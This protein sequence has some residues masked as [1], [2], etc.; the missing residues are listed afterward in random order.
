MSSR[1]N[2]ESASSSAPGSRDQK[3]QGDSSAGLEWPPKR[4]H[5]TEFRPEIPPQCW[6]KTQLRRVVVMT[7]MAEGSHR[8]KTGLTAGLGGC[9]VVGRQVAFNRRR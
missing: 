9:R 7:V 8:R 5:R 2:W 1:Q 3:T 4:S 6:Q